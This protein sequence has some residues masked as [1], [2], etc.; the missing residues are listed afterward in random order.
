MKRP[1]RSG[2]EVGGGGAE[3]LTEMHGMVR[4]LG[5]GGSLND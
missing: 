1:P 3:N 5:N 4:N 2:V